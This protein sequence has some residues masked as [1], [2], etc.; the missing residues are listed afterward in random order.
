MAIICCLVKPYSLSQSRPNLVE[1]C[2]WYV[3]PVF[4]I[5]AVGAVFF[6]YLNHWQD[7]RRVVYGLCI[8][9]NITLCMVSGYLL[10]KRQTAHATKA[11]QDRLPDSPQQRT[12]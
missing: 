11:A 8:P 10:K 9:A 12:A 4:S 6:T 7:T 3:L 5:T 2:V 1:T